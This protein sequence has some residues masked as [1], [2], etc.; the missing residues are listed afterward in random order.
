[1]NESAFRYLS[2]TSSRPPPP[3]VGLKGL[4]RLLGLFLSQKSQYQLKG[5][6]KN[7]NFHF[8]SQSKKQV[9]GPFP[10][11]TMKVKAGQIQTQERQ[12]QAA[13]SPHSLDIW[14]VCLFPESPLVMIHTHHC[15]LGQHSP[16]LH[17]M[18]SKTKAFSR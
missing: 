8:I 17:G 15:R 11:A 3:T 7:V 9:L 1:M 16:V 14:K 6:Q 12:A 18:S 10:K 13:A 4:R 5:F 2:A